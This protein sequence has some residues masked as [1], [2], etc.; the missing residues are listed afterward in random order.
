MVE[1]RQSVWGF[2]E[3]ENGQYNIIDTDIKGYNLNYIQ[4]FEEV[5]YFRLGSTIISVEYQE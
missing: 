5:T 1:T 4:T 2:I 3:E